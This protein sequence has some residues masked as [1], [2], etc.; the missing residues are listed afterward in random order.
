VIDEWSRECL[1]IKVAPRL[2]SDDVLA[3]LTELM[4]RR[5]VPEYIRSDNGPEFTAKRV[6]EW[7]ERVGAK[8]LFI[9]PGSPWENGY[10]ESFNGK[11]RDE[12]LNGEIFYTLRET[13]NQIR[14]HSSL[15]YRPPAPAATPMP[16]KIHPDAWIRPRNLRPVLT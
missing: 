8:T 7:I 6:R 12:L 3:T 5:G 10:N 9:E 11:L 1:A 15:G 14:P 4:I 2:R 16:G 13:Y